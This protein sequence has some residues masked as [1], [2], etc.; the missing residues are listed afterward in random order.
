MQRARSFFYVSL[1]VLALALAYHLGATSA[2]AQAPGN[3]VTALTTTNGVWA[4]VTQSGDFYTSPVGDAWTFKGN[5][6]TGGTTPA[7]QRSWGQVKA[8]HR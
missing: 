1:G 4:A 5:V 3:S 8:D 6:F 7:A 2:G